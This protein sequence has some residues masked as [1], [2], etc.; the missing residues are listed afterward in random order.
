MSEVLDLSNKSPPTVNEL[1]KKNRKHEVSKEPGPNSTVPL[2]PCKVCTGSATGYHFGVITC[3]ACKAFFRRAL[4]HKHEY[5]CVRDNRCT[6][7][8]KKLG[9]CSACRLKKCIDVGMSKG[10]VRKGRYS[11]AVRTR[12]IIEAK[13][14]KGKDVALTIPTAVNDN[15]TS[16]FVSS[17]YSPL[18]GERTL[19]YSS[20]LSEGRKYYLQRYAF[21]FTIHAKV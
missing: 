1:A 20:G 7:V 18:S 14:S 3:E 19:S 10:G 9:N 21:N 12:A 2:P 13:A 4:I 15:S 16:S 5:R 8:D 11:I 6:I 17:D